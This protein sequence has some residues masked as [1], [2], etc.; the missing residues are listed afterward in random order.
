MIKVTDGANAIDGTLELLDKEER[1]KGDSVFFASK[2]KFTPTSNFTE[3]NLTVNFGAVRSYA[4]VPMEPKSETA[5][6]VAEIKNFGGVDTLRLIVDQNTQRVFFALP[7]VASAGKTMVLDNVGEL[8]TVSATSATIAANGGA[9]F[10]FTGKM[11]GRTELHLTIEGI[12]LECYVPVVVT[13]APAPITVIENV[14]SED[15]A[16][17]TP[18][19]FIRN[20]M[21]FIRLNGKCY[22][23]TGIQ[24][25]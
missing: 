20:N 6:V 10:S 5:S 1:F 16:N 3:N 23:V 8:F 18:E 15:V 25:E 21:L 2:V 24:V 14:K 9:M 11:P 17:P 4:G 7:Q 19:K 12:G 22:T 13:A